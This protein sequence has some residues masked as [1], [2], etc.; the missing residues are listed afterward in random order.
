[1]SLRFVLSESGFLYKILSTSVNHEEENKDSLQHLT[2]NAAVTIKTLIISRSN[3]YHSL[4]DY[5]FL[6][7]TPSP[8]NLINEFSFALI[9]CSHR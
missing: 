3:A 4:Q 5:V 1:M 7:P 6:L 9:S 2:Q 8:A